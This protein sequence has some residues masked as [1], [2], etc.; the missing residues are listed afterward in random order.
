MP[1][2]AA[3]PARATAP[4][5]TTPTTWSARRQWEP[6]ARSGPWTLSAVST[7]PRRKARPLTAPGALPPPSPTTTA[8]AATT[9]PGARVL[10]RGAPDAA[11][12]A[13]GLAAITSATGN[14]VL[15]LATLHGDIAVRLPLDTTQ[16]A[17]VQHYDEYGNPLDDT[18]GAAYGWLGRYQRSADTLSGTLLMGSRLY[19]PVTGRFLRTDPVY[20]GNSD[21][22]VYPADPVNAYDLDG[23]IAFVVAIPAYIA[24]E[25]A[26]A[27]LIGLILAL[28]STYVC[29]VIG[30][31][32]TVS[33]SGVNV[34]WPD[35]KSKTAKKYKKKT[36]WGYEIYRKKGGRIYK[37]GITRAG[38]SRPA[39]QIRSC[40]R[41]YNRACGYK[42]IW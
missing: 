27:A 39:S 41:C 26:I 24:L 25:R 33:G 16:A 11:D 1:P 12:P 14:T 7:R 8:P 29:H 3:P 31:V 2:S 36:C 13:G 4:W 15:Q 42:M 28:V 34:P 20:G 9:P 38:K 17:E 19:S 22:Y 30:C 21:S 35:K 5:P 6:A 32:I 37:Y 18:A 23:R 40:E 10:T